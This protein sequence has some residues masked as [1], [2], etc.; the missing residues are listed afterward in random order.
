MVIQDEYRKNSPRNDQNVKR[1]IKRQKEAH[2]FLATF[3]PKDFFHCH[4]G[5]V[6]RNMKELNDALCIMTDETY[7]C[8]CNTTKADLS[9]W[10]KDIIGDV[11]LATALEK[12]TS[13]SLAAWEVATRISCLARQLN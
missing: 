10:V 4:D 2:K 5:Q 6:L 11:L 1:E 12:A 7:T 8:H 13:R 9:I 3:P